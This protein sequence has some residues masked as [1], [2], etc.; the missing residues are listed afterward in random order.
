MSE[1]PPIILYTYQFSPFAKR[2]AWYLQL[3]GIPYKA[4]EQP[5]VMPRPDVASLGIQYRRIPICSIGRDVYLDTRLILA[6]LETLPTTLPK[7]GAASGS[8]QAALER[9]LSSLTVT[10][11]PFVWAVTLLPPQMPVF[12]DEVWIKD[13]TGF[14]PGAGKITAPSPEARA[15]AVANMRGFVGMLETTVFADGR[16]W[17]L[18]TQSPSL[19]DIEAVWPLHWVSKIPGALTKDQ[20]SGKQF[21]RVFAWIERFDKAVGA[22]ARKLG[23]TGISGPEATKTIVAAPYFDE[24]GRVLQT[25]LVVQTLGLKQGDRVM[26]FPS[27]YGMTHKDSGSLVSIDEKEVVF[28]TKAEAAGSPTV[29]VHAPRLGFRIVRGEQASRL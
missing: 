27:D 6:K 14:F 24:A 17:I 4:C 23:A 2:I 15:E 10:G 29:R 18:N 26:V 9:T 8:E 19:A 7:L 16:E 3:R 1:L 21:P 28:E 20:L 25:D 11:G 5:P 13:R 12:K 22:A